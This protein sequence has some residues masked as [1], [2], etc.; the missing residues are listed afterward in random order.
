[1]SA[2]FAQIQTEMQHAIAVISVAV[3]GLA[4]LRA[5]LVENF[6]HPGDLLLNVHAVNNA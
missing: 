2:P 4:D 6:I 3:K 1:M 5:V